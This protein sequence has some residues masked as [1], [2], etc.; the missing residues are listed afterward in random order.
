MR[1]EQ[2]GRPAPRDIAYQVENLSLTGGVESQGRLV[3]KDDRGVVHQCPG[4]TESLAHAAAVARDGGI[5]AVGETDVAKEI[6]GHT[7]SALA[8]PAVEARVVAQIFTT[9]LSTGVPAALRQDADPPPYLGRRSPG[10]TG[11]PKLALGRCEHRREQSDRRRLARSVRA[12]Q[13]DHIARIGREAQVLDG[14]MWSVGLGE[15]YGFERDAHRAPV[16]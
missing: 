13:P 11:H 12:E 9:G 10:M 6:I 5:G 15:S 4:D 7:S 14:A 16:V 3:E 8:S 2:D 1:A